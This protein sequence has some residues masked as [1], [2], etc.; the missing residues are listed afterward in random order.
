MSSNF[1]PDI[2][3]ALA[4]DPSALAY[5][6]NDL[7]QQILRLDF[8]LGLASNNPDRRRHV[9]IH[10]RENPTGKS[11]L[12]KDDET[13]LCGDMKEL[14]CRAAEVHLMHRFLQKYGQGETVVPWQKDLIVFCIPLTALSS[15]LTGVSSILPANHPFYKS[16]DAGTAFKA[17]IAEPKLGMLAPVV[18]QFCIAAR[19]AIPRTKAIMIY[20][21]AIAQKID[22]NSSP[23]IMLRLDTLFPV[24][25][26]DYKP[27][28]ASLTYI[29]PDTQVAALIALSTG[30]KDIAASMPLAGLDGTEIGERAENLADIAQSG[31][32]AARSRLA[33]IQQ[34]RAIGSANSI[35]QQG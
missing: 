10:F 16:G 23:I 1:L 3:D 9:E 5:W 13:P 26:V 28:N 20:G 8:G 22:E 30:L 6:H 27:A 7:F 21:H 29:I 14:I 18:K 11:F 32:S 19:E 15:R 34:Q 4:D 2:P 17:V 33:Q 24:P 12:C 31:I 35:Q 25:D